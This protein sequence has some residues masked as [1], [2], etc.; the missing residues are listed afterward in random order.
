M[1]INSIELFDEEGMLKFHTKYVKTSTCWNWIA[2][3]SDKGYGSFCYNNK[4]YPAH[5]ASWTIHYGRIPDGLLVCHKCDNPQC[6][7]PNHLF[8]GTHRDNARDMVRKDR[9]NTPYS[10]LQKAITHCCKG[11]KFTYENTVYHKKSRAR[12]CRTCLGYT[13]LEAFMKKE[14]Y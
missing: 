13:Q 2:G 12:H 4:N 7:N 3:K 5:R 6:V 10:A 11:H 14:T 1:K 8:L 9:R